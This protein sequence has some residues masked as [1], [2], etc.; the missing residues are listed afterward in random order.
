MEVANKDCE[1]AIFELA[2]AGR[3]QAKNKLLE[4]TAGG[5]AVGTAVGAG[6][7]A[8]GGASGAAAGAATVAAIG[9]LVGVSLSFKEKRV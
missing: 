3:Y 2:E 5:I 1:E 6:L 4:Y 9:G 7:G 8:I